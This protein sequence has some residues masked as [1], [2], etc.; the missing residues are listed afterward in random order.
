MSNHDH[1]QA[2]HAP[3]PKFLIVVY[4][5]L[6]VWAVS[7]ALLAD[8]IDETKSVAGAAVTIDAESGKKIV[9][10]NCAACHGQDFKGGVG[11]DLHGV[12]DKLGGPDQT[13]ELISK[14]KGGMPAFEASLEEDKRKAVVEF[15]KTLK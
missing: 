8:R 13:F 2:G 3:I 9:T 7:Y 4:V 5:A 6:A 15:L 12:V 10:Q 1:D 14:G 11:P